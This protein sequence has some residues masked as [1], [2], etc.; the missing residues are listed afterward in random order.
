MKEIDECI[1]VSRHHPQLTP[2]PSLHP[3]S[4]PMYFFSFSSF[5][6]NICR[7]NTILYDVSFKIRV[8]GFCF[9]DMLIKKCFSTIL[10]H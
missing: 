1:F 5:P 7:L 4:P 3:R 6:S 9:G 2:H 10:L 8:A